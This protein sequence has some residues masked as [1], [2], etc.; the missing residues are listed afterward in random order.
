MCDYKLNLYDA[1]CELNVVCILGLKTV[2]LDLRLFTWLNPIFQS[3]AFSVSCHLHYIL[4]QF[5]CIIIKS[6][7]Y[8]C[9]FQNSNPRLNRED[10]ELTNSEVL[11]LTCGVLFFVAFFVAMYV[12]VKATDTLY[13]LCSSFFYMNQTIHIYEYDKK[14]DDLQ[15]NNAP[16]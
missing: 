5:Q 10:T 7:Q 13:R 12:E 2:F 11:T 3:K 14:R 4:S 8:Y 6:Q 9:P 16:V 1:Y 15:S